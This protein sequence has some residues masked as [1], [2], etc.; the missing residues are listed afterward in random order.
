MCSAYVHILDQMDSI[1]V[2]TRC[3][4]LTAW[5]DVLPTQQFEFYAAAGFI[6]INIFYDY[7]FQPEQF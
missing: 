2:Y 3:L 6:F 4:A 7:F 5:A 1:V